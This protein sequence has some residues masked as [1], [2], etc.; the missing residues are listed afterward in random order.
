MVESERLP[1]D[2][3]VERAANDFILPAVVS[4]NGPCSV[5]TA[6]SFIATSAHGALDPVEGAVWRVERRGEVDFLAKYVRPD[7]VD[8]VYLPEQSGGEPV[9]NWRPDKKRLEVA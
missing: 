2:T 4:D 3:V 7:K 8:G 5:E 1:H 9:W 6:L